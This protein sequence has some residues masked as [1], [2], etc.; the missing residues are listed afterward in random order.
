MD[1][2]TVQFPPDKLKR[3]RKKAMGNMYFF[4]KGVLG[5]DF[6]DEVIHRPLCR[7]L[8]LYDGYD[9]TLE[10][11]I[12]EY[13]EALLDLIDRHC[14]TK[15]LVWAP[16]VIEERIQDALTNGVKKAKFTL[17]RG[18]LKTTTCSISYPM[19]RSI[20][21]SNVRVLLA[22]NTFT[23]A[24]SKLASIKGQWETNEI[25]RA[26]FPELLPGPQSTWK[27][28]SLCL[29]RKGAFAESTYEACGIQTQVTSRHY[30]LIIEDDTVAPGSEDLTED[31]AVPPPEDIAKAIGWHKLTI[32][33]LV[34][35]GMGQNLVVGTRW[36]ERDIL[37]Y[38]DEKEPHYWSVER[39]CREDSRGRE[40]TS[41][42]VQY[43]SRFS[44]K[45]LVGIESTMGPYMFAA[46]YRNKPMSSADMTFKPEWIRY[47]DNE[48]RDLTVY[49]TIDLA[50]DP[51]TAKGAKIDFNVV[52]TTGKC[53]QT[54]T[55]YVLDVWRE[56][57]NPREVI[58]EIMRQHTCWNA[59]RTGCESVAYQASLLYWLRE[60]QS[61]D[62]DW[63]AVEGI[64][65]G[66]RSKGSRIQG[67]QPLFSAGKILL[68]HHQQSVVKELLAFPMGEFDDVID[69]LSMQSK[70]WQMTRSK[71]EIIEKAKLTDP[72]CVDNVLAELR[73][74]G[75]PKK[76]FPFDVQRITNVPS[77]GT[78]N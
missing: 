41:G 52:L 60:R 70:F 25:L 62:N 58:D 13:R 53:L 36:A 26:M 21:D 10:P 24:V 49:T 39:A 27:S 3:L 40:S 68:R 28:E 18:W 11:P 34:N 61:E 65:H 45:V 66:K 74:R 42:V 6:M 72:L 78:F 31:V 46:L 64:T 38:I 59:I 47:Y 75:L 57:A 43:Q 19:W 55:I 5:Y 76:G 67:L 50:T 44:E 51:A 54:G 30:D 2:K 23:N 48:P 56:R 63:F 12:E 16:E 22:Q 35:P 32:P 77:Y 1:V 29:M 14:A 37:S 15:Q 4:A 9:E 8:E 73:A 17:P 20:R 33:L 7:I 69:C 71:D